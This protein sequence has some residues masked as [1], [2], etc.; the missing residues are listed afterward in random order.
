MRNGKAGSVA[1]VTWEAADLV[2]LQ[3]VCNAEHSPGTEHCTKWETLSLR[4]SPEV[5]KWQC[6]LIL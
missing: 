4:C 6:G 2:E 3:N 1:M 5:R